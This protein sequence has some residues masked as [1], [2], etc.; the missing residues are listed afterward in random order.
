MIGVPAGLG[1]FTSALGATWDVANQSGGL[2]L[3][4]TNLIVTSTSGAGNQIIFGTEGK[5]AGKWWAEHVATIPSGSS[6]AVGWGYNNPGVNTITG[7]YRN[8]GQVIIDGST[9]FGMPTYA[10]G[11]V[12]NCALDL[13][14]LHI[15]WYVNGASIGT[16]SIS[17]GRVWYAMASM[18]IN[19]SIV[20]TRKQ[21]DM[22]NA[23]PAG[24]TSY[25]G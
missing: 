8:G 17:S 22:A 23:P 11:D 19:A 15:E 16:F 18:A 10:T 12:I 24:Y 20:T 5:S 13:D 6:Y 7:A 1:L 9:T 21:A 3:D 2:S 25:F 14:A 4:A